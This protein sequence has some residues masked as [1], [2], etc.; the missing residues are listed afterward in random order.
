MKRAERKFR[1]E[2]RDRFF[3][4]VAYPVHAAALINEKALALVKYAAGGDVETQLAEAQ[5]AQKEIERLTE[6]YNSVI[7]RGKWRGMM[8]AN[9]RAQVVFNIPAPSASKPPPIRS[10]PPASQNLRTGA[11]SVQANPSIML[12]AEH[13]LRFVPGRDASW[14]TITGL[15]YNGAAVAVFPVKIPARETPERIQAESPRLIYSICLPTPGDWSA[16]IRA[17]PAFSVEA[18]RP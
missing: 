3:E 4:L 14:R 1:P 2:A 8:T 9:P 13:A 5:R 16:T 17:L 7:A 6:M 11:G 18:G 10:P 12:E 15:G